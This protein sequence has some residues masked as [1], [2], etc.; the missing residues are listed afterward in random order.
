ML[1][2]DGSLGEGG[3][4]I[5]RS[6]LALSMVT[7][8]PFRI[9]KIRAGRKKPGLLRQ[10]LTAVRAAGEV[11]AA[12]MTGASMRS[13]ELTFEPGRVR[14]GRYA[15][16]VGT[17]GSATLVLQ[18]VLPALMFADG[19]SQLTLEGGTHNPWAPPFD[20]LARTLLPLLGQTGA[21]V[22]ASLERPGFYPAGGGKFEVSIEP[23]GEARRIDLLERGQ[24]VSRRG[25]ALVARLPDEI[26]ERE[27]DV[28]HRNLGWSRDDLR[29]E[30]VDNSAGPG[31]VVMLEIVSEHVTEV[32]TGFGQV[33]VGAGVV[34]GHAVREAKQYLAAGV[35]VGG[36]LADQLLV[37]MAL[38]GGRFRT[39]APTRHTRTNI[40]LIQRFVDVEITASK[41]DRKVWQIDVEPAGRAGADS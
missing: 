5:L 30:R 37:P 8:R 19:A 41:V 24:I 23:G 10:H 4:Q 3:G 9:E 36:H 14:P 12:T 34:A 27:L 17:A 32:F 35:P 21:V 6:S 26:A 22:T 33:R 11:C 28:V 25:R 31:N 40:D 15:F 2:I 13:G 20:F 7:G 38:V 1:T 39:I 29:V 18:T 16:A